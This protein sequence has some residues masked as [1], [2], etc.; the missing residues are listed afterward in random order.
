MRFTFTIIIHGSP[1]AAKPASM[2]HF[3]HDGDPVNLV[4]GGAR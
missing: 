2:I 4:Q 3:D 1:K